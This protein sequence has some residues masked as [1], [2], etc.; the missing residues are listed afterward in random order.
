MVSFLSLVAFALSSATIVQVSGGP[1][2]A[3]RLQAAVD[4]CPADGCRIELPDSDY[5]MDRQVWVVG[6]SDIAFVGSSPAKPVLR[7]VDSLLVPDAATI[8]KL[9]QMRPPPGASRPLLAPGW[10]MW[11]SSGLV[12]P[13]T[14][15]DSANP[16]A[17]E[18]FQHNGMF[19]VKESRGISFRGLVLDGNKSASFLVQGVWGG[20]YDVQHGSVGVALLRSF[21]AEISDCEIRRF[22]S[23]IYSNGR[24]PSCAPWRGPDDPASSAPAAWSGCGSVGAHLVERNRFHGNW[25]AIQSESEWDMGSVFR[26]NIAWNQ[27]NQAIRSPATAVASAKARDALN[28]HGGFLQTKDV[29]LA[30]HVVT[31]NTLVDNILPYGHSGY[32]SAPNAM[33]SHNVVQVP[34]AIGQNRTSS[35]WVQLFNGNANHHLRNSTIL[36]ENLGTGYVESYANV[37]D[38]NAT[39]AGWKT[40]PRDTVP[41]PPKGQGRLLL[42]GR[43]T[44]LPGDSVPVRIRT[45]TFTILLDTLP[46]TLRCTAGCWLKTVGDNYLVRDWGV[47]PFTSKAVCGDVWSARYL[48]AD[49]SLG[50]YPYLVASWCDSVGPLRIGTQAD[51]FS[52]RLGNLHCRNCRF[53][54]TDST[55]PD[56]LRPAPHASWRRPFGTSTDGGGRGALGSEGGPGAG[57]PVRVRAT[58]MPRILPGRGLLALPL[59]IRPTGRGID[60]LVVLSVEA[61]SRKVDLRDGGP[62]AGHLET[63][64]PVAVSGA[65][66]PGETFLA[67]D[68]SPTATDSVYQFDVWFAGIAGS[69]TLAAT[70][71]SWA[72]S[73]KMTATP[74][75]LE[76]PSVGTRPVAPR[77]LLRQGRR[78][79]A[80]RGR[81]TRLR[82]LTADGR[83]ATLPAR[84]ASELCT[85][86]LEALPR[87]V[88]WP[89]LPQ[90]RAI[91]LF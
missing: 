35:S 69:D 33:W 21:G 59:E 11:P 12:G 78:L 38:S 13:G 40:V 67:L 76:D 86:D 14:L 19:V 91:A 31:H 85:V 9:F 63:P 80:W 55:S 88:W 44:L 87:G 28:Q 68:F 23:A 7:W 53:L 6:R 16:W 47:L 45:D 62:P 79:L 64:R 90:A 15:A 29:L 39:Q 46:D 1:G 60:K 51:S 43:D 70:P 36:H 77:L 22:W 49:G 27:A 65:I 73:P 4:A 8:A 3:A 82:F 41:G 61:R 37:K 66:L 34:D 5:P 83:E 81:E 57:L 50:T 54:S 26:D 42:V 56:F 89:R 10:L 17:R 20:R 71:M 32:R 48:N 75:G 2:S 25:W 30:A 52:R 72:W 84:C 18:G 58:G 74:V 24:N